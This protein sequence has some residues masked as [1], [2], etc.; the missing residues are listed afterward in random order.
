MRPGNAVACT[1]NFFS[2]PECTNTA[3]A[4]YARAYVEVARQCGLKAI[5]ISSR[6]QRSYSAGP[7]SH[8]ADESAFPPQKQGE[9]KE[10]PDAQGYRERRA[11]DAPHVAGGLGR[12]IGHQL[13]GR[14]WA[15]KCS[16][17]C[18]YR[19]RRRCARRGP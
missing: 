10:G 11:M 12:D 19:C 15:V 7:L 2:L 4:A 3:A 9:I 1:R 14:R 6:M 17:V 18:A 8:N 16:A 5:D 13:K